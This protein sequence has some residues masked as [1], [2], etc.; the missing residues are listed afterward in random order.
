VTQ[1]FRHLVERGPPAAQFLVTPR[2]SVFV[3]AGALP[4]MVLLP[5]VPKSRTEV[6]RNRRPGLFNKPGL[7]ELL[8]R[9]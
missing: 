5:P 2:A 9:W 8:M 4:A 3:P 6:G 7:A 1:K